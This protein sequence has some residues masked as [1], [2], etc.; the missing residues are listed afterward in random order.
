MTAI[1][2]LPNALGLPGRCQADLVWDC[3]DPRR[4][5]LVPC[6]VY[7]PAGQTRSWVVF[8]TGFGGNRFDYARLARGWARAGHGVV[9]VEHP[10]SAR[11]AALRLLPRRYLQPGPGLRRW[12][13]NR[14]CLTNRPLDLRLAV[15]RVI[16][17]FKPSRVVVA[18]HSFGAYSAMAVAGLPVPG[19]GDFAHPAVSAL[20]AI[21]FQPPGQLF[22]TQDFQRLTLPALWVLAAR[23][24]TADGTSSRERLALRQWLPTATVVVIADSNHMDLA[25][26]GPNPRATDTLVSATLHFLDGVATSC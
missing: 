5:R 23:D 8:S 15:E 17:E 20:I 24:D 1:R 9:V 16:R 7:L 3:L 19:V 2:L 21:S 11:W 18:G 25:D 26:M 13:Y 6:A 14:D 22:R 12:V 10:G 4:S